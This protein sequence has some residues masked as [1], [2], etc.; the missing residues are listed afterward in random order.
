MVFVGVSNH[1]TVEDGKRYVKTFEVPYAMGHAPDVW[2]LY[3]VPY[4]PVTIVIDAKGRI[5]E[6]FAGPISYEQLRDALREVL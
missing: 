6:R 5:T 2:E 3:D 1:D 4:Q